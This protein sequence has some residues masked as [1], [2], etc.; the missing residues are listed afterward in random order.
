MKA[1][2]ILLMF[3]VLFATVVANGATLTSAA[4]EV[5]SSEKVGCHAQNLGDDPVEVFV[6]VKDGV[7][8]TITTHTFVLS[9]GVA[10]FIAGA[11]NG[12]K[13]YCKIQF[14]A[15]KKQVRAYVTKV[16]TTP[17]AEMELIIEAH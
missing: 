10:S 13:A 1:C 15:K 3:P 11:S 8:V 12:Q 7:G 2:S 5:N 6:E 14:A 16:D 17:P 4:I 9:P